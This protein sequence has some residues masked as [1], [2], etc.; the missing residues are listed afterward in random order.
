MGSEAY[1]WITR[2][3]KHLADAWESARAEVFASGKYLGAEKHPMSIEEAVELGAEC[4]TGSLLDISSVSEAPEFCAVCP[5]SREELREFFGTE[6]P[7][8][9][10]IEKNVSF[11]DSFGRGEARAVTL[12]ENGRPSRICFA[13]WTV[14]APAAGSG[15]FEDAKGKKRPK[16]SRKTKQNAWGLWVKP[17]HSVNDDF[18][19]FVKTSLSI[20]DLGG[21]MHRE[22][23]QYVLS[24][25]EEPMIVKNAR[26]KNGLKKMLELTEKGFYRYSV[27]NDEYSPGGSGMSVPFSLDAKPPLRK[28]LYSALFMG[29]ICAC[30][31]SIHTLEQDSVAGYRSIHEEVSDVSARKKVQLGDRTVWILKKKVNP[32]FNRDELTVL[33]TRLSRYDDDADILMWHGKIP[34]IAGKPAVSVSISSVSSD[35]RTADLLFCKEFTKKYET[36][37][38]QDE[39]QHL[40]AEFYRKTFAVFEK[41]DHDLEFVLLKSQLYAKILNDELQ[42]GKYGRN[43]SWDNKAWQCAAKIVFPAE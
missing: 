38:S 19:V 6:R 10:Q 7:T 20:W 32:L 18:P 34:F 43:N 16:K 28:V 15:S 24:H 12:Y 37:I 14:D 9:E 23:L 2:Y 11:R 33:L 41:Y 3:K 27:T 22:N 21:N 13:G 26:L 29:G 36:S 8:F 4:G 31:M 42:C 40:R 1:T 30:C 17:V 5:V 25:S 39:L 35:E